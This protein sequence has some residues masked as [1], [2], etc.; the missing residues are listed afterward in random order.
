MLYRFFLIFVIVLSMFQL[1]SHLIP[2]IHLKPEKSRV[3]NRIVS[4]KINVIINL[5]SSIVVVV[6]ANWKLLPLLFWYFSVS[7]IK[8]SPRF[9]MFLC[10]VHMS[11]VLPRRQ[12]QFVINITTTGW[13][14]DRFSLFRIT[15]QKNLFPLSRFNSFNSINWLKTCHFSLIFM[16]FL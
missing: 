15:F 11:S 9:F 6:V 13:P 3:I 12:L 5:L 14:W 7:F 1:Y 8:F 4:L 16:L 10:R 2:L